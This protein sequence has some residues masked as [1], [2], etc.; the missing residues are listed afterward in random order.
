MLRAA[1]KATGGNQCVGPRHIEESLLFSLE[2]GQQTYVF[3]QD[4][5]IILE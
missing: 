4:T 1:V 2:P 5:N 3:L